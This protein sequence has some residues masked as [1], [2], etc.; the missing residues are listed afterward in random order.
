MGAGLYSGNVV[1]CI[2]RTFSFL[3]AEEN[4]QLKVSDPRSQWLR[5]LRHLS[6]AARLLRSWIR[7]PSGAWMFVVCVLCCQVEVSSTSLSLVQRNPTD[8]GASLYV[9]KKPCDTRR[10]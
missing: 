7:I 8:C 6:T 9:I 10:P 2:H 4:T 5:G 3:V 1:A